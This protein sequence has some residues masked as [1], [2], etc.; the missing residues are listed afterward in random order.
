MKD[1]RDKILNIS[2]PIISIL[3]VL[4]IWAIA[5]FSVNSE[6]I[7]PSILQTARALIE[8]LKSGEFYSSLAFTL[9]RSV[10]AFLISF[11][12]AALLVFLVKRFSLAKGLITPIVSILRALPTVAV[13]LIL[14]FWTNSFIAP[15]IVTMLVI[16]PTIYTGLSALYDGVDKGQLLMCKAFNVGKKQK[17]TKVII[18][19]IAPSLLT[20]IGSNL[21]LNLKLMVAAEVL[22]ATPNS[23][24]LMLNTS[25]VFFEIASLLALVCVCIIFGLI[26]EGVF[27]LISK[28]VGKWQ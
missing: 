7:L 22:S 11:S 17:L 6:Y 26:I 13:V 24:G 1:K 8:V 4:V 5:S 9:L 10:I 15:I 2:L 12:I 21:S 19:Q 14:L 23:I 27:N 25:K 20:L 16:L 28:K 18:P 3:I